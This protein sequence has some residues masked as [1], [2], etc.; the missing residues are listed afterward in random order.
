MYRIKTDIRQYLCESRDKVERLIRNWVIRP[1]DLVYDEDGQYWRPIGQHR[2]FMEIFASMEQPDIDQP[3]TVVDDNIAATAAADRPE[4]NGDTHPSEDV[5]SPTDAPTAPPEPPDSVEGVAYDPD[6]VTEMTDRTLDR[7]LVDD[8]EEAS[9]PP[10]TA[11]ASPPTTV[12]P[13]TARQTPGRRHGLPEEAFTT[14]EL[15]EESTT[16]TRRESSSSDSWDQPGRSNWNIVVDQPPPE[17]ADRAKAPPENAIQDAPRVRHQPDSTPNTGPPPPA[18][19]AEPAG[20]SDPDLPP[21]T[22]RHE[23]GEPPPQ[24]LDPTSLEERLLAPDPDDPEVDEAFR[25]WEE[26]AAEARDEQPAPEGVDD[27]EPI[28]I[29]EA[30]PDR[31]DPTLGYDL[32]FTE[33]IKPSVRALRLGIQQRRLPPISRD[34]YFSKPQPKA[35]EQQP[36]Q[37]QYDLHATQPPRWKLRLDA[38]RQPSSWSQTRML[39]AAVG[40]A[41]GTVILLLLGLA[42]C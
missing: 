4:S 40:L 33:P 2:A 16:D 21:P 25:D 24:G 36:V 28:P 5:P 23:D 15:P 34:R 13:S 38:W 35:G 27:L 17:V 29:V 8:A 22:E 32:E 18:E 20:A 1:S 10:D 14:A 6:D 19:P 26:A 39:S 9:A 3:A 12:T 31:G 7:L 42:A 30:L 11:A 37:Q 41:L